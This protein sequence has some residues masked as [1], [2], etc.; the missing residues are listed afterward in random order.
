MVAVETAETRAIHKLDF[1]ALRTRHPGV[2]DI[3]A[4]ALALRVRR[5]SELL[6]KAHYDPADRRVLRRCRSW[7]A[8]AASCR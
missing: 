3:L 2:S 7:R 4:T 6:V 8:R 1:D 5:L